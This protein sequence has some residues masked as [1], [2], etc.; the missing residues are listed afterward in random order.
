VKQIWLLMTEETP[1]G[2]EIITVEV[3]GVPELPE[4]CTRQNVLT[5]VLKPRYL[6]NLIPKDRFIAGTVFQ[7]TGHPEK[8]AD[9]K[10]FA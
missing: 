1:L 7:N 10:F 8:I 5:V 9:T 2:E 6:S 4:K 3:S